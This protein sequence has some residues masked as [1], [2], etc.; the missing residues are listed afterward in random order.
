LPEEY[1]DKLPTF[2]AR[3][4]NVPNVVEGAN[5]F[6]WREQDATKNSISM[7]A[8]SYYSHKIL[9]NKNGSEMQEML[10]QKGINWNDYPTFFRRGTYIQRRKVERLF[11]AVEL[12][13]LPLKHEARRN[14]NLSFNRTEIIALEL[15]PLRK[16]TNRSEVVFYGAD[17]ELAKE[18][19]GKSEEGRD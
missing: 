19:N 14:P 8:R 6:L 10:F 18:E 15:P 12:D 13:K 7:A 17:Y 5:V 11:T 2:D 1:R 4:W 9:M 16:I 3:V